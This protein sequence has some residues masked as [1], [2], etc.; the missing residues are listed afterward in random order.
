VCNKALA[1]VKQDAENCRTMLEIQKTHTLEDV[2]SNNG[3][4][5]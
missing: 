5:D 3:L 2:K 4:E 1:L